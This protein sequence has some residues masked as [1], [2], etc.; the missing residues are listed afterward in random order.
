MP[1]PYR[2]SRSAL[3][4]ACVLTLAVAASAWAQGSSR[5]LKTSIRPAG[6]VS[7]KLHTEQA[8]QNGAGQQ[9]VKVTFLKIPGMAEVTLQQTEQTVG[10]AWRWLDVPGAPNFSPLFSALPGPQDYFLQFTWDAARGRCDFYVN[11][12]TMRDPRFGFAPWEFPRAPSELVIP[13][14]PFTISD[15]T[16]LSEFLD[17]ATARG[18][19]PPEMLDRHAEVF[20]RG[21]KPPPVPLE[22]RRGRVLYQTPLA[23]PDEVHPWVMEGPGEVAFADGWMKM[24][25]TRPDAPKGTNGHIVFWCPVDFPASFIAEWDVQILEDDGLTIV[26]FAAEG[27]EGEDIF[28]PGLPPRDGTFTDYTRGAVTSYHISY[29]ASTPSFPGRATA[30]LRKNNHFYLVASG[31]V[32]IPARSKAVH[33]LRLIKDGPHVQF[34]TDG[35]VI[36]DYTDP[37]GPRYGPVHAGGKIALRQMQWTVGQYRNFRVTELLAEEKSN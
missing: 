20:G 3:P 27:A 23:Q 13:D 19:V 15:L 17:T 7:F 35:K 32:A 30:N 12:V 22:A 25:S 8:W 31:P 28:D 6:T 24:W 37:G 4:L 2:K 34:Q 5:P 1:R 10:L 16:V 26:F 21:V 9:K 33:R 11:G 14:G 36:L 29:Y 18:R